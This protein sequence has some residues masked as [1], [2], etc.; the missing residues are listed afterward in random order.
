MKNKKLIIVTLLAL[1]GGGIYYFSKKPKV[2]KKESQDNQGNNEEGIPNI[3]KGVHYNTT[4]K[5]QIG[6]NFIKEGAGKFRV[7]MASVNIYKFNSKKKDKF[8]GIGSD[9]VGKLTKG[10]VVN[11]VDIQALG[12]GKV[13][14]PRYMFADGTFASGYNIFDKI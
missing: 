5:G 14:L 2:V 4:P 1:V 6:A 3:I 11:V 9:V 7:K 12:E 8:G 10:Q 13:L